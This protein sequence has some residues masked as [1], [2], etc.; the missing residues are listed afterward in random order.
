MPATLA[1]PALIV[2]ALLPGLAAADP[3]E[4]HIDDPIAVPWRE[5]GVDASRGGCL[6]SDVTI[7]LGGRALLEEP[8]PG[9]TARASAT[10][11][12]R[13]REGA[14]GWAI[15]VR[16]LDAQV[17]QGG[18]LEVS[19]VGYGPVLGELAWGGRR[20]ALGRPL[21]GAVFARVE[22]PYTRSELVG[23]SGAIQL[24]AAAT[25][26]PARRV[27]LHGRVA[28]LGGYTRA[29]EGSDTRG[30][31]LVSAD[32][33]WRA[34]KWLTPS[35]GVDVQTGWYGDALDHLAVRAGVHWR[36][37][38]VWRAAAAAGTPLVGTEATDLG[39]TLGVR[40]DLD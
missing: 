29:P 40:R 19:D 37:T 24:G 17:V 13:F 3:C 15:G 12:A 28:L 2:L 34:I 5:A 22:L 16:M 23:S 7:D 20:E 35:A 26:A 31:I 27:R 36:L 4:D 18:G 1:R 32:L 38:G 8:E 10:F 14:L 25:W 11:L 30:A 21:A 9:D 33:S 6:R 39:V